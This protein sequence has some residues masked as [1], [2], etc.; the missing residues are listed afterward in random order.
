M[1]PQRLAV[2]VAS[3][4][5]L[6]APP[7]RAA[8]LTID[9]GTSHTTPAPVVDWWGGNDVFGAQPGYVG[10]NLLFEG[11]AGRRYLFT[12]DFVDFEAGWESALKTGGGDIKNKTN[13]VGT[14]PG[15]SVAFSF[16][17]SGGQDVVPFWFLVSPDPA[18]LLQDPTVTNDF[19]PGISLGLPN[20]FLSVANAD[21]TGGTNLR[22]GGV[23]WLALDDSGAGPDTDHDDWV[24]LVRVTAVPEPTSLALL[25]TGL[26]LAAGR[27]R[28]RARGLDAS[29]GRRFERRPPQA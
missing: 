11:L 28:R 17:A 23:V 27:L 24:G 29:V 12:F 19:N 20:F 10:A 25:A 22:S 16:V 5:L 9:G 26:A 8:M 14:T 1:I 2:A 7:A 4:V 15:T 3:A 6:A 18:G 21:V 13:G